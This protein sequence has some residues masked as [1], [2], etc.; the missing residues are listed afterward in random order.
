MKNFLKIPA[1]ILA[2]LLGGAALA[3]CDSLLPN[4]IGGEHVH[5]DYN[6][7]GLCDDCE[8]SVR[9]ELTF[10]AVNDLH[11]KFMDTDEQKGLD[12]FTTY[13]KNLYADPAR[14]EILLSSGDM[15]QGTVESSSTKGALM[16]EWMNEAGFVSMTLG[17]HEFDWGPDILQPNSELAEFPFLG[18]NVTYNGEMPDYCKASTVVEKGGAK[19]GIIGAIGDCLSSISGEFQ[20]GLEF[21]TGNLLTAQVEAE[22]KR[23]R[24]EEGCDFI[25]YSIH[26]GGSGFSSS[27]VVS[28]KN[29]D[30]TYYDT[31]LSDGYVDLVFEA[32][33]HKGYT[34][35]DEHG[36][37]HM[38]AQ[39][40]NRS[41]ARADVTIDLARGRHTVKTSMVSSGTY[42]ASSIEGDPSV[43]EIFGKYFPDENPYEKIVGVNASY[44]DSEVVEEK[45]AEL[46]FEKGTETWGEYDIVLAGGFLRTRTPYDLA[47][48]KVTYAALFSILPFDNAIVLGKINGYYLKKNF[49]DTTNDDYHVCTKKGFSSGSINNS[50]TYY[51]V[52][53]TYTAYYKWN[54]ITE[55]KR[56]DNKT[57]ARDLLAAF[58]NEA[59]WA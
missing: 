6:D 9:A 32:H 56:L 4:P 15:W 3:G 42:A 10:L 45:V 39:S 11:G 47:A 57:Y 30:M 29:S 27:G 38:Q 16:T 52:V 46:Y 22:A 51:I 37:Y 7:D 12:E 31:A 35:K 50:Q 54:N 8:E 59:G 41:V 28:V 36:V 14:E 25:V 49:I 58:I 5:K 1:L 55:V 44:R 40:D 21:A 33:T 53:D 26:D 13:L 43:G 48:G 2:A 18:I 20:K 23:L 24:E 19:I 17:N 34:L